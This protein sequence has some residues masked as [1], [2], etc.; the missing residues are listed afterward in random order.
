MTMQGTSS[1]PPVAAAGPPR[2]VHEIEAG[3]QQSLE[4][5]DRGLQRFLRSIEESG[6]REALPGYQNL[7][8]VLIQ[9]RL[10]T[11][12]NGRAQLVP[13]F[14]SIAASCAELHRVFSS[15]A[16]VMQPLKELDK[17]TNPGQPT[18]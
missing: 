18:G 10:W 7:Q 16:G 13:L 9:Q 1:P 4:A 15:Y 12:S 8:A 5:V 2:A 14:R 17:L 3:L 6:L 11:D